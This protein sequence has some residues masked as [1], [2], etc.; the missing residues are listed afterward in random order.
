MNGEEDSLYMNETGRQ[1]RYANVSIRSIL[2]NILKINIGLISFIIGI[3]EFQATNINRISL[4]SFL[5][6]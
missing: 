6:G 4:Y 1:K 5:P 3:Q 2:L